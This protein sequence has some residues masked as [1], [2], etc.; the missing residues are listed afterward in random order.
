MRAAVLPVGDGLSVPRALKPGTAQPAQR[1]FHTLPL[2]GKSS[3]P[4][5]H[6]DT[7]SGIWKEQNVKGAS[8][9]PDPVIR[10]LALLTDRAHTLG[11][12]VYLRGGIPS[13]MYLLFMIIF[14]SRQHFISQKWCQAR[15]CSAPARPFRTESSCTANKGKGNLLCP[16]QVARRALQRWLAPLFTCQAPA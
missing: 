12:S 8:V 3:R 4:Q 15:F 13:K 7:L 2:G 16:L 14:F 5:R 6:Q 11:E 10:K 1:P 9:A